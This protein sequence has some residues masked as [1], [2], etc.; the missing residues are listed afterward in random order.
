MCKS[1]NIFYA[2]KLELDIF[3]YFS[4]NNVSLKDLDIGWNSIT[5]VGALKLADALKVWNNM[6]DLLTLI[7]F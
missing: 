7:R 2:R 6:L 3:V 5:S 1:K 4:A